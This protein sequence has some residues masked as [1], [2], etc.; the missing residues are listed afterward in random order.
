[1]DDVVAGVDQRVRLLLFFGLAPDELLDVRVVGVEDHHLGRAAG[2]AA[3]LDDAREG[4]EALH[5]AERAAG[6][7][8]APEQAVLLAQRAERLVPVPEPHLK[9]MPSVLAR[10]RIDSSVSCTE[11]MKQAEHWGGAGVRCQLADRVRRLVVIPAIAAVLFFHAHVEPDRRIEAGL[12]VQHQ[13][14]QFVTEVLG[15]V[16]RGEI[17]VVDAPLRDRVH[18]AV[19]E[20]RR[21][22]DSRSGDPIRPWKYL[23]ATMLVAV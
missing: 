17:A 22:C 23:L 21:R 20:L 5:E 3:G 9:S 4:V 7:S 11:L 18:D 10:S 8:A 19:N 15:I 16:E 2:L 1:M 14:R 12:L 13:V 6:A